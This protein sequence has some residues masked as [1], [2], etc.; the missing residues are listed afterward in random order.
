[1]IPWLK[2]CSQISQ[3]ER[4][5]IREAAAAFGRSVGALHRDCEA[6]GID[7]S[8]FSG[9][10]ISRQDF[11]IL[12][13]YLC[14]RVAKT[15]STPGWNGDRNDYKIDCPTDEAKLSCLSSFDKASR[16]DCDTRF[17]AAILSKKHKIKSAITQ[18]QCA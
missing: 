11:W 7:T 3:P 10:C 12:Y 18:Y 5:T 13:V 6:L 4:L 15:G 1:M 9:G 16:E 17:D 2:L 8:V 14:W